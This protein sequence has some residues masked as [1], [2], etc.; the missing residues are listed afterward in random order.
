MQV[1]AAK[2]RGKKQ[3]L[4]KKPVVRYVWKTSAKGPA[5][6]RGKKKVQNMQ[7]RAAEMH[8]KKKMVVKKSRLCDMCA[9]KKNG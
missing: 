1:R 8:G 3:W 2:M 4:Q 5:K 7:L 6:M 9:T